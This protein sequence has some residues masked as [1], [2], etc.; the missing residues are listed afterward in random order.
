MKEG[1]Q[2]ESGYYYPG[3]KI[4]GFMDSLPIADAFQD[5]YL[6]PI[7]GKIVIMTHDDKFD[8]EIHNIENS[9]KFESTWF[10]LSSNF[11]EHIAEG[12]DVQLHFNKET[13]RLDE[14]IAAFKNRF[15]FTPRFNRNHRLLWKS[16]NFDFPL[17]SMNGIMVD[18]TLIGTRPFRPCINGKI[19]LI[20][21][22]PFCITDR[23]KRFM[24]LY[25]VAGDYEISFK[26]GLSP[27]VVLSH[28]FDIC[29]SADLSSCFYDVLELAQKYNYRIISLSNFYGQYLNNL[30]K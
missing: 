21:E 27:I 20:W 5:Q 11:D 18:S 14:Q 15:G 3:K 2:Q 8:S 22:F 10:L 17:L 13:G 4:Q 12:I 6:N 1:P 9:L 7:D 23:P 24:A 30:N 19:I 26:Y 29:A 16:H 28:P 25:N